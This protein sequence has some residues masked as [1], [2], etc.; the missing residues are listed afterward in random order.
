[1]KKVAVLT[2][3]LRFKRAT[4]SLVALAA[5]A[6]LLVGFS[7]E[8][9]ATAY[10]SSLLQV[11]NGLFTGTSFTGFSSFLFILNPTSAKVN[12]VEALAGG[13]GPGGGGASL[14][15]AV[16]FSN[17]VAPCVSFVACGGFVNNVFFPSK[18]V[19]VVAG[20]YAVAD[21]HEL[22]TGVAAGTGNWGSE[23]QAQ[24]TGSAFGTAQTGTD[25]VLQW[26]FTLATAGT[27]TFTGDLT[28]NFHTFLS[29]PGTLARATAGFDVL[30]QQ[31]GGTV[32]T[33][34]T[35]TGGACTESTLTAPG[36]VHTCNDAN[37][38][39]N[40]DI[41]GTSGTLAAGNYSLLIAFDTR[42]DV[43][44]PA[45][46]PNPSALMLLGTGLIGVG[47]VARRRFSK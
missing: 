20:N 5:T 42:S 3:A 13:A 10:S 24:L 18:D 28:Q 7:S 15:T 30:I 21:T 27:V 45:V 17:G 6:T 12:A 4:R 25:N 29:S 37:A 44:Q 39:G 35:L 34:F 32:A 8:A 14:D 22:N 11:E 31:G 41:S 2:Q 23:T 47:I 43:Q 1:M 9:G 38:S 16:A 46:V 26:N 19:G 33:L 36:D 40:I